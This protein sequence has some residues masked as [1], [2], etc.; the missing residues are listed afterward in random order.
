MW[1]VT[2]VEN[3]QHNHIYTRNRCG[4]KVDNR[5]NSNLYEEQAAGGRSR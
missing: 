5:R 2:H 1:S 3:Y 4:R